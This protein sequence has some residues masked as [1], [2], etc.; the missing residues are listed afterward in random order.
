MIK[1][2]FKKNNKSNRGF[3]LVETLVAI[4]IFTTAVVTFM[5]ILGTGISN[6][7]YAKTKMIASYLAQEGVE[8]IRNM[9]DDHLFY[10]GITSDTWDKFKADL[11]ACS[12]N[13]EC[14]FN[15]AVSPID[16]G[17]IFKCS[18]NPNG[19]KIYLNNGNYNTNSAGDDSGFTRTIRMDTMNQDEVKI[20]SAVSWIQGSGSYNITFSE[21]LFNWVE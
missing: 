7:N 19:C 3:T 6:T 20:Y 12:L 15:T 2:Y 9:R 10:K 4:S 17:F 5:S 18:V 13:S 14:G 16:P 8:Y 21:D 1:K 11:A